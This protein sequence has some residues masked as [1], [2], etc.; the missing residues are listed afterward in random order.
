[1]RLLEINNFCLHL[2]LFYPTALLL[3]LHR[4]SRVGELS[5]GS[6]LHARMFNI[7]RAIIYAWR[8]GGRRPHN[9]DRWAELTCSTL[10]LVP[11]GVC[12]AAFYAARFFRY[13]TFAG[14][15][16]PCIF[17][18]SSLSLS[19]ARCSLG[20]SVPRTQPFRASISIDRNFTRVRASMARET[21]Y[22]GSLCR[23]VINRTTDHCEE[24][25]HLQL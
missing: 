24:L 2:L 18:L 11:R 22:R 17:F 20:S 9:L 6:S 25:S 14:A 1:M 3:P 23:A 5:R 10:R 8:A 21:N 13:L 19:S 7:T 12:F 15:R 4:V 16:I